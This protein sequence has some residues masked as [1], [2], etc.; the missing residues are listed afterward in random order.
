MKNPRL[1]TLIGMVALAALSRLIPHPYNF[2]PIAGLALFGGAKFADKRMAFLVPLL[3]LLLSE[4]V[5]G[6]YKGMSV[7]YL[8]FAL[9]VCIGFYLKSRCSGRNVVLAALSGSVLFYVVTNFFEWAGGGLY[10]MT[11]AGLVQCYVAA[12]PFFG[13][14]VA[15]DL[16]YS[17]VLFGGLAWAENMYPGLRPAAV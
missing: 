11:A 10:P 1:L 6:F 2:T 17:G 4:A 12:I 15:G 7:V 13:N 3:A 5:L 16:V 8:S 14:T 9:I